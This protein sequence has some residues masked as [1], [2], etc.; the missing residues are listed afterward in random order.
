MKFEE[1]KKALYDLQGKLSAYDHAVSLMYYDGATTAPKG[2]SENRAHSLG[3]LTE[4]M[5]RIATSSETL[6]L[7]ER[8]GFTLSRSRKADLVVRACIENGFYDIYAVNGKLEE[9]G[10]EELKQIK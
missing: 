5:Y 10:C 7:L 1:A 2:T 4:E 8:A 9:N 3:I 6:D